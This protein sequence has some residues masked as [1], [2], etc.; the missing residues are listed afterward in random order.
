MN[1]FDFVIMYMY[2]FDNTKH[3]EEKRCFYFKPGKVS[4]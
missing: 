3:K 1:G 2:C 4:E